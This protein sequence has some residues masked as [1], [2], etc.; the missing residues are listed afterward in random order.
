MRQLD[1]YKRGILAGR[2]TEESPKRY[3]FRYND[4]YFSD[5]SKESVSLT[6]PK[7]QQVYESEYLFPFFTNLLPEGDNKQTVCT[8]FHLD[9]NDYFGLLM[10]YAGK[11]I[12]GNVT[13][14]LVKNED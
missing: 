14:E 4:D 3:V 6:L 2:L 1:V 9:D 11:D 8:W 10:F 7:S 5:S 12:I 13:V